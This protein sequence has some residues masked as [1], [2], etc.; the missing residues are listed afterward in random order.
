MNAKFEKCCQLE[1][2]DWCSDPTQGAGPALL[3]PGSDALCSLPGATE[4]RED[5]SVFVF[6]AWTFQSEVSFVDA[7]LGYFIMNK[8]KQKQ[9]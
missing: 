6:T 7:S 9:K 8:I 3:G 1:Y 4:G 2:S 5:K